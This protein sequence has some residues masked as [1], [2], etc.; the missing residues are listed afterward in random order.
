MST[1]LV[2]MML[3]PGLALFYGGLVRTK[4]VPGTIMQSAIILRVVSLLWVLWGYFLAFG[5]D[6]GGLIGGLEWF[7]LWPHAVKPRPLRRGYRHRRFL[8]FL[9]DTCELDKVRI[10]KRLQAYKFQLKTPAGMEFRMRQ[11]S[12]SCRFVWNRAF[13][14]QQE[15]YQDVYRS[16]MFRVSLNFSGESQHTK[17]FPIYSYGYKN[18]ADLVSAINVKR[19]GHAQLARGEMVQSG[20]SMNQEPT[21]VFQPVAG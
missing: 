7:G 10:M 12:G 2:M 11:F 8:F 18:H 9:R 16:A 17:Q 5:P 6:K 13:A 1:A 21:E 20:H 4:N 15:R 19:A 14:L 3:L